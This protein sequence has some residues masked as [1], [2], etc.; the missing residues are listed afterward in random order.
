MRFTRYLYE[1]DDVKNSLRMD[2]LKNKIDEVLFWTGELYYS[3]LNA[4]VWLLFFTTYYEFYYVTNVLMETQLLKLK[5][6][7]DIFTCAK[8]LCFMNQQTTFVFELN[9]LTELDIDVNYIYTTIS[10]TIPKLKRSIELE[11]IKNIGFYI[12]KVTISDDLFNE[13]Q[14][15]ISGCLNLKLPHINKCL[16]KLVFVS[17]ISKSIYQKRFKTF[18]IIKPKIFVMTKEEIKTQMD[19][20]TLNGSL[21]TILE[22]KRK[23]GVENTGL[24]ILGYGADI[25]KKQHN[26]W[27][28]WEYYAYQ[29]PLWRERIEQY[30]GQP[31]STEMEIIFPDEDIAEEFYQKF[32]FEPDEQKP[33]TNSKAIKSIDYIDYLKWRDD[34]IKLK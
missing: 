27:F 29:V 1:A 26:M 25:V 14:E 32:S 20:N 31:S 24:E 6:N 16:R 3:G 22:R 23:Y 17:R 12:K 9:K 15:I 28:N 2:I 10:G 30:R 5:Q 11:H 34:I 8:S 7:D 19:I 4:E 33:E 13:A 18:K 21:H